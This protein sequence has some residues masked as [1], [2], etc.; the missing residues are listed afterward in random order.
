MM[1]P[2]KQ[3]FYQPLVRLTSVS[4][5]SRQELCRRLGGSQSLD[6]SRQIT[7]LLKT[8]QLFTRFGRSC[9][10]RAADN[11]EVMPPEMSK[12]NRRSF[13]PL[14]MT[15]HLTVARRQFLGKMLFFGMTA[16]IGKAGAPHPNRVTGVPSDGSSTLGWL[17]GLG[18]ISFFRPRSLHVISS[19]SL[20][21]SLRVLAIGSGHS[22][23]ESR[24]PSCRHRKSFPERTLRLTSIG[25]GPWSQTSP[26]TAIIYLTNDEF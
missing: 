16:L 1:T 24:N 8:L 15:P 19:D 12:H 5:G 3:P 6:R 21:L 7:P 13:A 11:S 17:G 4:V 22:N 18:K 9:S 14:R 20:F 23:R 25:R 26:L 10:G 2:E